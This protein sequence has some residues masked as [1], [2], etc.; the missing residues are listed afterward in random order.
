MIDSAP[1]SPIA[2]KWFDALEKQL[3]S[4]AELAGLF[5]HGGMK[6]NAREFFVRS[7]LKSV[8]PPSLHI[9]T[10]KVIGHDATESKQIDIIIYDPSFPVF[11]SEPGHGLY[12]A[13][14]VIAAIEVKSTLDETKLREAL[15][16]CDSI[17]RVTTSLGQETFVEKK[18]QTV[19]LGLIPIRP[20]TYVFGYTSSAKKLSTFKDHIHRW[21]ED[22]KY[23]LVDTFRFPQV[24]V[25]GGFF[26]LTDGTVF[27]IETPGGINP[28]GTRDVISIHQA[29]RQFGWL[30]MHLL[31][32]ISRRMPERARLSGRH[33]V[34]FRHY[35]ERDLNG[36]SARTIAEKVPGYT[37]P[38]APPV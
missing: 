6:G 28:S 14:G 22:R 1:V 11:E 5:S 33:Y 15:D 20:I 35:Y 36:K 29:D 18:Q 16:N 32:T 17:S 12:M 38:T 23:E 27:T 8:L 31:D 19:N 13:E 26:A 7:A 3:H 34:P 4:A 21:W 2:A 30:L 24:I 25:S 9:G 37:P 10:G